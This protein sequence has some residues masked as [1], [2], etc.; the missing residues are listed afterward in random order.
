MGRKS[1]KG[2]VNVHSFANSTK[3]SSKYGF[4]TNSL[5][6]L[7]ERACNAAILNFSG[8][9]PKE[10]LNLNLICQNSST[11]KAKKKPQNNC[12][13]NTILEKPKNFPTSS[14]LKRQL[15]QNHLIT[16]F[17]NRAYDPQRCYSKSIQ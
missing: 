8:F 10:S 1:H 15:G 11:L 6:R 13:E 16:L 14:V 2:A 7:G 12:Y 9:K 17:S 3:M 5:G 4:H